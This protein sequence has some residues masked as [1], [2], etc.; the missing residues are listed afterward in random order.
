MSGHTASCTDLLGKLENITDEVD[1]ERI[2]VV[3]SDLERMSYEPIFLL[4]V[5]GF[6]RMTKQEVLQV[7]KDVCRMTAEEVFSYN[8]QHREDAEQIKAEQLRM[9]IH[10]FYLLSRLRKD[11]PEAWDEI[12]ELYEDD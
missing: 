10:N 1:N 5:E 11:E 6:L 3:A 9:L 2:E 8:F 7:A 12:H 4:P